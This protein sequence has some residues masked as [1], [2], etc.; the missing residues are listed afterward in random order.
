MTLFWKTLILLILGIEMAHVLGIPAETTTH[1]QSGQF[2]R[3][4]PMSRQDTDPTVDPYRTFLMIGENATVSESFLFNYRRDR[5]STAHGLNMVAPDFLYDPAS[6]KVL[7][8]S[9]ALREVDDISE[10]RLGRAPGEYPNRIDFNNRLPP[11]AIIGQVGFESWEGGRR[12]YGA[13]KAAVQGAT[14]A[15]SR[16]NMLYLATA[17]GK[18]G[19]SPDGSSEYKPDKAV[20]HVALYPEGTLDIGYGTDPSQRPR[21][22]T[23]IRGHL[24]VDGDVYA[25]RCIELPSSTIRTEIN[26]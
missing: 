14:A 16:L 24:I 4:R 13:L 2:V 1:A 6:R 18:P 10:L 5:G 23:K 20:P 26:R 11:F 8:R 22:T 19:R 7:F 25:Q 21:F 12:G 3:T 15:D 9:A 17:T